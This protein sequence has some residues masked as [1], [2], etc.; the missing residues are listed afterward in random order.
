MYSLLRVSLYIYSFMSD[1]LHSMMN[2]KFQD[3]IE[4]TGCPTKHDEICLLPYIILDIKDF[5]AV[6]FVS[7]IFYLN[8]FYFEINF[9]IK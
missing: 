6:Y 3:G 2:F 5:F 7:Q 8:I 4:H 9:T 1:Q